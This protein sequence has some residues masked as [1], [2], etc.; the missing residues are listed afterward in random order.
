MKRS[1][2]V[3]V[4]YASS[5]DDDT[6]KIEVKPIKKKRKLPALSSSLITPVP[7]DNPALHQGRV[8]TQPHVDGQFAAYVYVPVRVDRSSPL[9]GLLRDV[10]QHARSMVGILHGMPGSLQAL[11]DESSDAADFSDTR[12]NDEPL[13][14]HISLSRPL[15]LRA[16]QRDELKRAVKGIAKD[17]TSFKASFATFTDLTNDER[18]RTFLAMEVGAGHHEVSHRSRYILICIL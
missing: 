3:L 6:E 9:T 1:S 18:T 5:D 4:S 7:K 15:L 2:S 13:E 12:R 11:M 8:R 16:H 10:L 17:H 14:L